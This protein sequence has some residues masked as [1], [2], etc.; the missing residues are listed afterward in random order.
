MNQNLRQSPVIS[1]LQQDGQLIDYQT[2]MNTTF[3]TISMTSILTFSPL[4]TSHEGIY[5]C[6][7]MVTDEAANISIMNNSSLNIKVQSKLIMWAMFLEFKH[8]EVTTA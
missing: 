7:A 8:V 5:C 1:W 4:H 6:K 2:L 3:N